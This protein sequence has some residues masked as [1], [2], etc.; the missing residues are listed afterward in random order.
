[1][2]PSEVV[3][4]PHHPWGDAPFHYAEKVYLE[5]VRRLTGA[6]G[7]VVWGPDAVPR[8]RQNSFTTGQTPSLRDEAQP[9]RPVLEHWP[10]VD[11]AARRRPA[12]LTTALLATEIDR[13]GWSVGEHTFGAPTV[14]EPHLAPLRIGKFCSIGPDVTIIMGGHRP[15]IVTTYPFGTKSDYWP[16]GRQFTAEQRIARPVT[17]GNDVWIGERVVIHTGVTIGHGAIVNPGAIVTEDVPPYAVVGGAPARFIRQRF[18]PD[19]CIQ[20][21]ASRWWEWSDDKVDA[22]LPVMSEGIEAFLTTVARSSEAELDNGRALSGYI[23][24]IENDGES[25]SGWIPVNVN[26][27]PPT[28]QISLHG[29]AIGQVEY[30]VP[31]DD[32]LQRLGV[33]NVRFTAR[34]PARMPPWY[35]LAGD[36]IAEVD[37]RRLGLGEALHKIQ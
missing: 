4:S 25:I 19:Q 37:G 24:G 13:W 15:N 14:R 28:L 34:L 17:I 35:L 30:G 3:S 21:L 1:M 12:D 29:R 27:A 31:R 36:I 23:D 33:N 26:Q 20:L 8:S 18:T 9:E 2:E 6:E 7:R 5:I 16:S 22:Y 11:W 32:V 10:Q